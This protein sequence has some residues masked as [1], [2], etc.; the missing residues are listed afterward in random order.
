VDAIG[1]EP[2]GVNIN[3]GCGSTHMETL[4]RRVAQGGHDV[5]FA[6]DGDGDRMLAVAAD[7][8]VV[9]GDEIIAQVALELKRRGE[10]AG[11]GVAVTVM[12][13]F[14]FHRAMRDA[15]IEVGTTDVGDRH[16]VEELERRGWV[17]GGEQSGH[18]VDM[19]LTP[20]GDG[21]AAALL[22][23]QA[24]GGRRLESGAVMTKLPQVLTNVP[25]ADREALATA[26]TV[27]EAVEAECIELEG[28][29]RVLVRPSGTEP[30][31]R[32]M[33]EA[34]TPERC[35]AVC[36]RVVSV[37]ERALGRGVAA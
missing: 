3:A 27:W 23:L 5:G 1:R 21:I 4:A 24:L 19:R 37:V 10:L 31:V 15:G 18:I 7:G 32:V 12:T 20:S 2:D 6:F 35:E 9:D 8:S 11:D 33:V 14:G 28:E 25:V 34:P 36:A 22:L 26:T 16:V 29:G 13:N 17:L 30:V